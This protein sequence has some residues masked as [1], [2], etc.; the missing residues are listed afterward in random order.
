LFLASVIAASRRV[1]YDHAP[2]MRVDESR[3]LQRVAGGF[4]RD[5]V[6]RAELLGERAERVRGCRDLP[7]RRTRPSAA[8]RDLAEVAV[9]VEPDAASLHHQQP[10]GG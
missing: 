3:D 10:P 8:D 2:D 5:A 1:G 4:H 7:A 9:H 6:L